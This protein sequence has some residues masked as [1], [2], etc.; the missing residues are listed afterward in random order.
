MAQGKYKFYLAFENAICKDYIT[1]KFFGILGLDMVPVVFGGAN[2]SEIAPPHS[3]IDVKDFS[4]V[5]KL[6]DYLKTLDRDDAKYN[7]YFWWRDFY[8]RSFRHHQVLCDV[9]QKL[10]EDDHSI[11]D[12]MYRWWVH[13]AECKSVS[14][15]LEWK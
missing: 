14:E 7:E 10:N 2:Y 15:K 1:E 11:Y 13:Q 12:D 9:C 8:Q 5:E 4:S 6:A 3:Y